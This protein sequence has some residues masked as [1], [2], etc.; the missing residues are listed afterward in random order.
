MLY[1]NGEAWWGYINYLLHGIDRPRMFHIY[2]STNLLMEYWH[3]KQ[4]PRWTTYFNDIADLTI[5]YSHIDNRRNSRPN[6]SIYNL[7]AFNTD[8]FDVAGKN[9]HIHD[10]SIWN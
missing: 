10:V 8:G 7:G 9:V 4:A 5:R 6:H 1:G 3:F 2:N